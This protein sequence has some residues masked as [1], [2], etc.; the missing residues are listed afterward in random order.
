MSKF[1]A[2]N[3]NFERHVRESFA[4]QQLMHT[5]GATL[6]FVEPGQIEIEL[7]YRADLTQQHG[8]IHAGVVAS[9]LDTACGY[10][11]FSLMPAGAAVLSIE[12][13]VNLLTPARGERLIA[14]AE[15]KRAGRTITVCTA[16]A[17]A[18]EGES[19][20]VVATMVAT[21]MCIEGREDLNG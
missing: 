19:N 12:F 4:R 13:K 2:K 3:P 1:Q 18:V 7:P 10:A 21:I 20:K 9:V 5:L 8:F 6:T 15:V 11:A 16:D 14:R 17:Y